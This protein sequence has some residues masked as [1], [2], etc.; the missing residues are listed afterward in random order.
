M[1]SEAAATS[2]GPFGTA[3]RPGGMRARDGCTA[4][5]L[6]LFKS[7]KRAKKG[8]VSRKDGTTS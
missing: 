7:W 2:V 1:L 4:S 6:A 3:V 8:Q 5:G